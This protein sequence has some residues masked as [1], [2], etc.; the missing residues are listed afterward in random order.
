M[1]SSQGRSSRDGR[2]PKPGAQALGKCG[3]QKAAKEGLCKWE[4]FSPREVSTKQH[5]RGFSK[6]NKSRKANNKKSES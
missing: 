4:G 6:R 1:R 3:L 2:A 5:P